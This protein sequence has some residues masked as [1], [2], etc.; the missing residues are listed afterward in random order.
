MTLQIGIVYQT[1]DICR[2]TYTHLDEFFVA[3]SSLVGDTGQVGVP[4]LTVLSNH[5]AVVELILSEV[6]LWVVVT[7]NVDLSQSI[8]SGWFLH[9]FMD[10]RLKQ[11]E[12]ELQPK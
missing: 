9:T 5:T 12:E 10:T 3:L 11:R 6:A 7:V 4:F 2:S 1:A 8:V